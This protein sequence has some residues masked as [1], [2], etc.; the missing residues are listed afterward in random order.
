MFKVLNELDLL[1]KEVD[2]LKLKKEALIQQIEQNMS[3]DFGK[4][5][6]VT[7]D[8]Y[9]VTI[10]KPMRLTID[11]EKWDE[12]KDEVDKSLRPI[13]TKR[14]LDLKGYN[15]LKENCKSEF[16]M[17]SKAVIAKPGK[18]SIKLK[19]VEDVV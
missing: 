8:G 17:V 7:T 9:K 11:L 12:I 16:A 10:T 13:R 4:S 15:Y 18:T 2:K 5:K 6:T 14:E 19:V 1:N 3:C